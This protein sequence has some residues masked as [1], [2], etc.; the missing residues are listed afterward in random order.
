MVKLSRLVIASVLLGPLA[1]CGPAVGDESQPTEATTG[2]STSTNTTSSMSSSGTALATTSA[3]DE[4]AELTTSTPEELDVGLPSD[5]DVLAQDCPAGFKCTWVAAPPLDLY[6]GDTICAP[7][8]ADPDAVGEPCTRG[9]PQAG[10][11]SCEQGTTC[12]ASLRD[13]ICL[14]LCDSPSLA[15]DTA[16]ATVCS[17]VGRHPVYVCRPTCDPLAPDCGPD[18]GCFGFPEGF[19]CSRESPKEDGLP[20]DACV[21]VQGCLGGQQCI[22]QVRVPDCSNP[23]SCCSAFCDPADPG[24]IPCLPGQECL[25][26]SELYSEVFGFEHVGVCAIP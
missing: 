7:I 16:P 1:A 19:R 3:E 26:W 4:T 25:P 23:L 17:A 2:T 22:P 20:G 24:A 13:P 12:S 9:D 14:Q 8:A 10:V 5:C 11:D 21:D 15:C 18:E 6:F